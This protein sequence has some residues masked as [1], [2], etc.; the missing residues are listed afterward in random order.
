MYSPPIG[1]CECVIDKND[2][3]LALKL[4]IRNNSV[5]VVCRPQSFNLGIFERGNSFR[6]LV[7]PF[8]NGIFRVVSWR[9]QYLFSYDP[10]T[11]ELPKKLFVNNEGEAG[12]RENDIGKVNDFGLALAG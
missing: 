11:F 8:L 12:I 4:T 7:E 6:N 2:V 5:A 10:D 1:R 9:N 3:G